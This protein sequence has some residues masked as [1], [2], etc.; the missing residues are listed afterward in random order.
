MACDHFRLRSLTWN[1]NFKVYDIP[2]KVQACINGT[3]NNNET[4]CYPSTVY[5]ESVI[6]FDIESGKINWIQRLSALDAWTLACGLG[7]LDGEVHQPTC[8]PS[9]G[10]DADFGMAPTFVSGSF[11]DTPSHA[12]VV[13][14]SQKNAN[15]YAI[16]AASGKVYWVTVTSVDSGAT[17]ALSWG[18]AVDTSR[19]YFTAY[20]AASISWKLEPSG[21]NISNSAYGAVA[22]ENGTILWE[23]QAPNN[24]ISFAPPTVTNDVVFVG[25]GEPI[26]AMLIFDKVTGNIISRISTG[27]ITY[28]GVAVQGN[29]VMFGTGYNRYNG[30]G[31][32]NV[33]SVEDHHHGWY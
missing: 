23:T 19:V 27:P 25:L 14:V 2:I 13:V 8:P 28:G 16:V 22:L 6:A 11:A 15:L 29:F 12:D 30:T 5:Q 10:I 21:R 32:F 17:G 9:P 26:G 1:P 24:S 7:G 18:V 33:Y 4:A 31:S 20:D 3:G